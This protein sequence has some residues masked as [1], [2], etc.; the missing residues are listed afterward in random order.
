MQISSPHERHQNELSEKIIDL[1][2]RRMR[3]DLAHTGLPTSFW[4]S[5]LI[6]SA[7]TMN[8]TSHKAVGYD[9]PYHVHYECH[10]D[11]RQFKPL[12]CRCTVFRP[13]ETLTSK[14]LTNRCISCVFV[15]IGTS[16]GRKCYLAYSKEHNKVYASS[17]VEFDA[18]FIPMR[19]K[20]RKEYGIF[21]EQEQHGH[22]VST[23]TQAVDNVIHIINRLPVENPTWDPK[24]IYVT[25]F[26]REYQCDLDEHITKLYDQNGH[27][28]TNTTKS[29]TPSPSTGPKQ[30]HWRTM[31]MILMVKVSEYP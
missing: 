12:G 13:K 23:E 2:T 28:H 29:S 3:A 15:V 27:T 21:D 6:M 14:K 20:G 19:T 31:R 24:D 16:F 5:A 11:M 25:P 22:E 18:T 1:L 17:N 30:K 7:D 26:D 9:T 10:A 8:V 4:S